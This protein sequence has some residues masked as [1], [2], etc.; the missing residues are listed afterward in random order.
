MAL[1]TWTSL[2][3]NGWSLQLVYVRTCL[4]TLS[5]EPITPAALL[6]HSLATLVFNGIRLEDKA[7]GMSKWLHQCYWF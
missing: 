3:A 6:T 1:K 4:M 7:S 2:P 5:G